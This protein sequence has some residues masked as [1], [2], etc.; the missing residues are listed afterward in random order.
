[1]TTPPARTPRLF[2]ALLDDFGLHDIVGQPTHRH[3]HQPDVFVTRRDQSVKSVTVDPPL[4]SDHSLITATFDAA[5]L[6]ASTHNAIVWRCRWASFDYD[7]FINELQESRL[8]LDP[9]TDVNELVECYDTTLVSLLD[10][11]AP[12]RQM[13]TTVRPSAPWYDAECRRS[14]A[15]TRKL[16]KRYRRNPIDST[17]SAWRLQFNSQ[18]VLFQKKLTDYWSAAI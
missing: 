11:F 18:S 14:K 4:L 6:H 15:T 17:R 12:R 13:K 3:G 1:L 16:E 7:D 9:P 5:G 2:T 8:V 10:K